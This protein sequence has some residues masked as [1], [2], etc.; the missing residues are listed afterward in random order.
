M[1]THAYIFL[2]RNQKN[3][4]LDI[5]IILSYAEWLLILDNMVRRNPK[6]D[7]GTS[8]LR[9]TSW[10]KMGTSWLRYELTKVRVDQKPNNGWKII[11]IIR[12]Y[13]GCEG[14]KNP[15]RGLL[16]G[17]KRLAEWSQTVIPRDGFF[18]LSRTPM[19]DSFSC[20]SF[21]SESGLLIMQSLRLQTFAILWW[22]YRD[23]K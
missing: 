19:I 1:S 23:V 20:I 14:Q 16:S 8:W 6:F 17:I 2:W 5:P 10:P 11:Y 7:K 22:Q 21:I 15:S 18:Y 13:H 9:G 12:I 3:V 4:Y